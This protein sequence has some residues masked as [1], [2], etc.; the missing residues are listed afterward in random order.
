M[1]ISVRHLA[2]AF[3][4]PWGP[5]SRIFSDHPWPAVH[6]SPTMV[7]EGQSPGRERGPADV[8]LLSVKTVLRS[9]LNFHLRDTRPLLVLCIWAIL[10]SKWAC[11]CLSV[12]L[13]SFFVDILGLTLSKSY[14]YSFQ[15]SSDICHSLSSSLLFFL[16]SWFMPLSFLYVI[17]VGF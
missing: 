7:R 11:P 12:L 9:T 17:L 15:S 4:Y 2:P 13:A 1:L 6:L 16:S 10:Q 14:C 5:Q 3:G 8:T